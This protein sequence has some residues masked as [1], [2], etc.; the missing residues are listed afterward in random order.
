MLKCHLPSKAYPNFPQGGSVPGVFKTI[1]KKSVWP[2]ELRE[3]KGVEEVKEV[4]RGPI[5]WPL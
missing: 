1:A 3:G 5:I 4:I 2:R